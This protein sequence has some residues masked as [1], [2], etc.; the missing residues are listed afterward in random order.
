MS[1]LAGHCLCGAVKFTAEISSTDHG[2]CHC[3]MC[4]R[5][6]GG[7][8]L[9]AVSASS[10]KF[11]GESNVGRYDSSAWGQRCFCKV[12]G[13][14][15]GYFLKPRQ[16]YL[17]SVGMF[18]DQAPFRLVSQIFIDRKPAGYGYS[19]D[20]KLMTEAEMFKMFASPT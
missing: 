8:G 11:E 5:W 1:Q 6:S 18:E 19:G 3:G 9:F 20:H 17:L 10:V 16:S 14:N 13:T 2:V 15:I 7:S 4:R 12:C